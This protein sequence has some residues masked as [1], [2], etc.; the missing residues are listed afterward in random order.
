MV[1]QCMYVI[2][3][4]LLNN[5]KI[6]V[7]ILLILGKKNFTFVENFNEILYNEYFIELFPK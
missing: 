6:V 4:N 3:K 1:L 7:S 2:M 5:I